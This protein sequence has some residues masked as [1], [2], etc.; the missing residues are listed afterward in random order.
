MRELLEENAVCNDCEELTMPCY[1]HLLEDYF[2]FERHE[3]D[4]RYTVQEI[5]DM[6]ADSIVLMRI[7]GHLTMSEGGGVVVDIF[8]CTDSLVDIFWVV[9]RA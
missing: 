5:A 7:D 9:G 3:C 6:Y 4:Y 2:G 1:E 8:N